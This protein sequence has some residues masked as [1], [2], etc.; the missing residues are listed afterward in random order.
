[1]GSNKHKTQEVMHDQSNREYHLL[2]N[3][4]RKAWH[5]WVDYRRSSITQ[6]FV[7]SEIYFFF[8]FFQPTNKKKKKKKKKKN[9]KHL[10]FLAK[11][12]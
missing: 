6:G 7:L 1:M 8:P 4:N 11:C 9:A 3:Q 10:A 2:A 5:A 12:F